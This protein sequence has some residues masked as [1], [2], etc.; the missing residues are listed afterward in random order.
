MIFY[1]GFL[2][3]T[4]SEKNDGCD[5]R[6]VPGPVIPSPV[7]HSWNRFCCLYCFGMWIGN[8][9]TQGSPLHWLYKGT[10]QQTLKQLSVHQ[11]RPVC[12]GLGCDFAM[13]RTTMGAQPFIS[14]VVISGDC[15]KGGLFGSSYFVLIQS[16]LW[17][18]KF[19]TNAN[20]LIVR[21]PLGYR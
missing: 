21:T 11:H 16:P 18:S 10:M 2:I 15:P 17:K 4:L 8:M 20:S 5:P 14:S 13:E 9:H 12:V 3:Y 6:T 7:N 19:M 1:K